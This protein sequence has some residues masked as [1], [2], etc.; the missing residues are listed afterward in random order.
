[1]IAGQPTLKWLS[2]ALLMAAIGFGI[3]GPAAPARA[4]AAINDADAT[5][6]DRALARALSGDLDGARKEIASIGETTARDFS[7]AR[8][9]T[10]QAGQGNAASAG[11]LLG[12]ISDTTRRQDAMRDVAI[13]LARKGD[14][15]NASALSSKLAPAS[16]D[17]LLGVMA[18]YEAETVGLK[19]A[20]ARLGQISDLGERE[21]ATGLVAAGRA[22]AG[23]VK[24][25]FSVVA[26][27]SGKAAKVRAYML[28][29]RAFVSVDRRIEGLSA[30]RAG[31]DIVPKLASGGERLKARA[32]A[33]NLLVDLGDPTGAAD[34]ASRIADAE[35]RGFM[36]SV[37][38]NAGNLGVR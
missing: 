13:V 18:A 20:T 9:A 16:R 19:E 35:L 24:T 29:A 21:S 37:I 38:E 30:V 28:V 33:V 14:F 11:T 5:A 7:Y 31:L 27:I 23:D 8:L 26:G 4:A 6:S 2:A 1:M 22:R 34:Q 32:D 36:K 15:R 25:A 10:L 17:R 12:M 3:L